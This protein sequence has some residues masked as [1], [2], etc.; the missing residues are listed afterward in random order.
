[1]PATVLAVH[2]KNLFVRTAFRFSPKVVRA[3]IVRHKSFGHNELRCAPPR[4]TTGSRSGQVVRVLSI[5]SEV[6]QP[7]YSK[8]LF[9]AP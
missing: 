6:L 8:V 9:R 2:C 4:T 7:L 1:V 5:Q 3:M